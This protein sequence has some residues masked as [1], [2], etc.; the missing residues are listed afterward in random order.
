MSNEI[1]TI[2]YCTILSAG[3]WDYLLEG[4]FSA[5]RQKCL[6]RLMTDAV[7]TRTSYKIKGID[8]VL[9]VGQAAA[10]DVELAEFLGCNRKTVGKLIDRFNRLGMLTTRT[11]NRTSVHTLH[12]LTGWYVG[13]VLITNP[14]YVRPSTTAKGQTDDVRTPLSDSQLSQNEPEGTTDDCH[15]KGKEVDSLATDAAVLSSSLL[16]SGRSIQSVDAHDS[17]NLNTP[18]DV[19][20]AET[21]AN[22]HITD[23]GNGKPGENDAGSHSEAQDGTNGGE[24]TPA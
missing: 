7:R 13:G 22:P 18:S 1:Q 17:D 5:F 4:R 20:M 23:S 2:H 9:E 12:F 15:T 11:N 24:A 6:Y 19:F 16:L 3:Q 8:I 10:S 21:A 14:H